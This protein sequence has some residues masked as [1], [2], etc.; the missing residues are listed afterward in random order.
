MTMVTIYKITNRL[1]HTPHVS[2]T[3]QSI[4]SLANAF[5]VSPLL[6]MGI[7]D[8]EHFYKPVNKDELEL[9][10]QKLHA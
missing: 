6:I 2:Q 1:N 10:G 7:D 8:A 3:R 4:A 9:L 5:R